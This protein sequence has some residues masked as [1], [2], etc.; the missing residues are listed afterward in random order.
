M[1]EI[2]SECKISVKLKEI[3]RK[4]YWSKS[5][6]ECQTGSKYIIFEIMKS[7]KAEILSFCNARQ[8]VRNFQNSVFSSKTDSKRLVNAYFRE[9]KKNIHR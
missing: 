5:C 2:H 9:Y 7:A 6:L 4:S 1:D 3:S 8:V